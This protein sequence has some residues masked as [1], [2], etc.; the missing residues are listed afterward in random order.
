MAEI[1]VMVMSQGLWGP[2]AWAEVV[3]EVELLGWKQPPTQMPSQKLFEV[4][5][6]QQRYA[7]ALDLIKQQGSRSILDIG[8]GEGRLLEYLLTK[9]YNHSSHCCLHDP[10]IFCTKDV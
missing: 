4:P 8:C 9:V 3:L 1:E 10:Q 5:V 6:A 2:G 7:F